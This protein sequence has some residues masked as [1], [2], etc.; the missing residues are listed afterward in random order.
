MKAMGPL[1]VYRTAW[2]RRR[3]SVALDLANGR[4]LPNAVVIGAGKGGT[5][6]LYRAFSEHPE[7]F[8]PPLKVTG[9]L[10]EVHFF[11]DRYDLGV[12]HYAR[13]FDGSSGVPVRVDVSPRYLFHKHLPIAARMHALLPDAR[14]VASLRDPVSRAWSRFRHSI[15][16]GTLPPWSR[17]REVI[18]DQH[19]YDMYVHYGFYAE[20]L[21]RYFEHY[22][23]SQVKVVFYEDMAQNAQTYLQDI[24]DFLQVDVD[25]KP[26]SLYDRVNTG[27][28]SYLS[29]LVAYA[30]VAA[31]GRAGKVAVRAWRSA[32]RPSKFSRRRV[33]MDR[34]VRAFLENTY[35]EPNAK[36]CAL[37]GRPVPFLR[38]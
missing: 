3:T 37:L 11:T 7:I 18:T 25:F 32:Q 19:F 35:A 6:W 8:V 5:S 24:L 2:S 13:Y 4:A 10:N 34:D 22:P 21:E 28:A 30:L 16:N 17:F 36:L 9:P 26:R 29:E 20:H 23:R 31:G 15:Q 14:L 38:S 33:P 27:G 12:E 1:K